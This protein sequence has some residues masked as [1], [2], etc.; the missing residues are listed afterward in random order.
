MV[1]M[2]SNRI[3]ATEFK[4][5][6]N[7]G[8]FDNTFLNGGS[9]ESTSKINSHKMIKSTRKKYFDQQFDG[10]GST[11]EKNEEQYP[12]NLKYSNNNKVHLQENVR[13]KSQVQVQSKRIRGN[14][15]DNVFIPQKRIISTR[16]AKH[17]RCPACENSH[18]ERYHGIDLMTLVSDFMYY[19]VC[20]YFIEFEVCTYFM[21][22]E[23]CT[24]F[25]YHNVCTYF[26]EFI[27]CT[28]SCTIYTYPQKKRE[29]IKNII[30][31]KRIIV[32][33]FSVI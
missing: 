31:L 12:T 14:K 15:T 11:H 4:G 1:T 30:F 16:K 24:Y 21:E 27:V 23:V 26:M 29:N 25:M 17:Q 9:Q 8:H 18:K 22:F 6:F 19:K 13:F 32:M 33:E 20:T 10:N 2:K 3:K 28:Y 5:S 7:L